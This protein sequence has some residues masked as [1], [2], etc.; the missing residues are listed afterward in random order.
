MGFVDAAILAVVFGLLIRS[1][2]LA[3]EDRYSTRSKG[4]IQ[5]AVKESHRRAEELRRERD[6][7]VRSAGI[8]D[9]V[10]ENHNG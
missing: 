5:D 10:N 7:L 9:Y 3:S 1:N 8:Q 2:P 4:V 6:E